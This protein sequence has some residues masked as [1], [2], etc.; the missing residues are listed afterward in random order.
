[1]RGFLAP[2]VEASEVEQVRHRV[3]LREDYVAGDDVRL[4]GDGTPIMAIDVERPDG[5]ADVFVYAP[6]AHASVEALST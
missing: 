4:D 3:R 5:S 2:Y 1:M 6:T